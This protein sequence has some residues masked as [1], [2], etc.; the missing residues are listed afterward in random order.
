MTVFKK[1]DYSVARL[2]DEIETG[3][4][5][6]PDIQRPFVWNA[7]KVRNL[8]DSM[9]QGFPV[10]YLLFWSNA[11]VTGARQI[12]AGTKQS[13]PRLLI[14]DGQQ[15]LTSLY[16]V[17][18]GVDVLT[19]DYKSVRIRIAFRPRDGHFAVADAAIAKDPEFIGDITELWT[20]S[21]RRAFEDAFLARLSATR[22]VSDH[23]RERLFAATDRL[24]GLVGYAFTAMELSSQVDEEQVAE[25]FVRINS[26][27]VKLNQDDFILTLMSVFWEDGR[28]QL[29]S[30]SRA[31]RTPSTRIASPFNHFIQPDPGQLLRVAVALGFRR[32]A[33]RAV[34]SLLR[35]RDMATG[36]F[37]P[38]QRDEQFAILKE[39]QES[40]LDLTNWHEFLKVLIRAGFRSSR[41]ITSNNAV[42]YAY[43]FYL[44]GRRDHRV[45]SYRLRQV[46]ARWFFMATLTG[47]YTSSPESRVEQDLGRLPRECDPD[48]FVAA[49]DA[50]VDQ[51][52][53]PDFWEIALPNALATSSARSPE[54]FAYYAAL[55]LLDARVLFSPLRVSELFDP[56]IHANRAALERH[57]L[58][59]RAYL[60]T[61]GRGTVRESN[62][63]ANFALLEWPDNASAAGRAPSEYYPE[64]A[65][66]LTPGELEQARI[67]HAL[68]LGWEHM[69]Y[70]AFLEQ[71]RKLM[72]RTIRLG[73]D[74]LRDDAEP[75]EPDIRDLVAQGEGHSLEFKS[76]A[77]FNR[78]TQ[79]RDA[80]LE[81]VVVKTVAAFANAGGGT[82]LVGIDDD[83]RA[84]GLDDDLALMAKGDVDRYEL[85]LRELFERALGKIVASGIRVTFPS[86]DGKQIC[87]VDV[88]AAGQPVYANRPKGDRTDDFF[89][90]MGNS[91]RKLT[92]Q[93]VV[94][95]LDM[96]SSAAPV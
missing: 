19:E 91:T 82:L 12:G 40:T 63:I 77:R 20:T 23:E 6:L 46:V 29:E 3:E 13:P 64:L 78:H 57:H 22:D 58:Y 59:P 8:F 48:A 50:I 10:G 90:R 61:I 39:A 1:V 34:Y 32:G 65:A 47:R 49:L 27:G 68:P 88:P 30:F 66:R 45:E 53:T 24:H 38:E 41:M 62:Q 55:V 74:R 67:W 14:V 69:E 75:E 56:A 94:D 60:A 4:I 81:W 37:S 17:M 83:G 33:L 51:T 16:A 7:T 84:V 35:G 79:Q 95:Y 36:Q 18:R 72:A 70:D 92:P 5:G 85:W 54:L 15:R 25:V 28:K 31:S 71:R 43:A 80:D 21:A 52:L 11:G 42:L 2:I 26:Q 44:L 93:E 86:L 9:Y 76:T 73:F 96:R 89:V 87:R